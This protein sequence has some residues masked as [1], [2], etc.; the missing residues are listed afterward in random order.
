MTQ[1]FSSP[2]KGIHIPI[3]GSLSLCLSYVLPEHLLQ[4]L[5]NWWGPGGWQ[6]TPP[7]I[8]HSL[9]CPHFNEMFFQVYHVICKENEILIIIEF[10]GC[11]VHGYCQKVTS[12]LLVINNDYGCFSTFYAL[13]FLGTSCLLLKIMWCILPTVDHHH[14]KSQPPTFNVSWDYSVATNKFIKDEVSH[15]Q[16]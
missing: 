12:P 15:Q 3:G 2:K 8:C 4:H 16:L 7:L 10:L 9:S 11:S 6:T 14:P 5:K 1:S 13:H